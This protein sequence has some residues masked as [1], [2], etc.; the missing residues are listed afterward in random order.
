MRKKQ[1]KSQNSFL[2]S[3][4]EYHWDFPILQRKEVGWM[5]CT[6]LEE[7]KVLPCLDFYS[8]HLL[9]TSKT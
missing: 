1:M 4:L 5:I 6:H 3:I 2:N 8:I 7:P 9:G